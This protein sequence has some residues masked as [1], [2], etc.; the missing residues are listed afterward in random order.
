VGLHTSI[1]KI[2]RRNKSE[3][4]KSID[5]CSNAKLKLPRTKENVI[6]IDWTA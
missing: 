5:S 6:E 2:K 4:R 1:K 3:E